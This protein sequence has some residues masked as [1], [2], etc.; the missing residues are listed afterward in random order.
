M[1]FGFAALVSSAPEGASL[2]SAG[3]VL[4]ALAS[5]DQEPVSP[6]VTDNPPL[7]VARR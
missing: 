3:S 1:P 5:S 6:K 4:S 2:A 7:F